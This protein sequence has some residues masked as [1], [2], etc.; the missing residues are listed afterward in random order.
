ML[1]HIYTIYI[2]TNSVFCTLFLFFVF[3]LFPVVLDLFSSFR[4]KNFIQTS[5][6]SFSTSEWTLWCP[7]K[8][9]KQANDLLHLL[10]WYGRS[11]VCVLVWLLSVTACV[12]LLLQWWHLNG[13]S[14]VW[15]RVCV[16]KFEY[17]VN[18]LLQNWQRNGRSPVWVRMW[19]RRCDDF[20]K[21]FSQ[22]IHWNRFCFCLRCSSCGD[23]SEADVGGSE[24]A[25]WKVAGL[26]IGSA[27]ALW[28]R[29]G[30]RSCRS[31]QYMSCGFICISWFS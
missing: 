31:L 26:S 14:P 3:S 25:N 19:S 15:M 30:N 10:Q 16:L 1:L 28:S 29:E 23:V 24:R 20:P 9:E 18:A 17:C 21:D 22:C 8:P 7:F 4:L 13:F 6:S 12:K 5:S 2:F 27:F 11:P